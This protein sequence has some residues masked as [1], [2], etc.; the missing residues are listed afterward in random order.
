MA[1]IKRIR[2]GKRYSSKPITEERPV[3]VFSRSFK[4]GQFAACQVEMVP[5]TGTEDET[6]TLHLSREDI[7]VLYK[8]VTEGIKR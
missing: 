3:Q 1:Y 5:I 8:S 4:D 7:M 2:H 6:W